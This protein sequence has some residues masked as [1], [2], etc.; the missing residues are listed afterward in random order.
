MRARFGRFE[1]ARGG[2]ILLDE[3][4]AMPLDTQAKLLR[5]LQERMI[6]RL[7][8]NDAVQLDVRFIATSKTDPVQDV[9]MGRFREY[10]YW[11][12]NVAALHVPPCRRGAKIFRCWSCNCCARQ[13]RAIAP[14]TAAPAPNCWPIWPRAIGRAICATCAIWPI[15]LCWA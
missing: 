5:L 3:V 10:L 8:S 9:A 13:A 12:L 4:T 2:T 15:T 1:H 11:R 14:L 7:G 6:T